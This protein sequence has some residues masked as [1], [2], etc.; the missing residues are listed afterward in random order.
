MG[1]YPHERY[2]ANGRLNSTLRFRTNC[3]SVCL[4]I[5]SSGGLISGGAEQRL[6]AAMADVGMSYADRFPSIK[7]GFTPGFEND[8]LTNFFK[9]PFTYVVGSIAGSVFDFGRKN[10]NTKHP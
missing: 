6:K 1:E 3:L 8:A 4:R 10:G 9:S 5:C 2:L 7:I